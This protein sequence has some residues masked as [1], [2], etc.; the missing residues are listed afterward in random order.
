MMQLKNYKERFKMLSTRLP[1]IILGL[2]VLQF[3]LGMLANLYQEV[4]EG[5]PQEVYRQFGYIS[6][7]ALNA[8]ALVILAI[9][10]L[11]KAVRQHRAVGPAI[12]G[13]SAIVVAYAC[14][15]VFVETGND[16]LSFV[17]GLAFVGALIGYTRLAFGAELAAGKK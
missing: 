3:I 17:M 9:V 4:P 16:V 13:L 14:G 11:V 12:G 10:F 2:L 6:L 1:R 8:A 15:V 5:A 7:H